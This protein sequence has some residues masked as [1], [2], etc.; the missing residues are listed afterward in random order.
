MHALVSTRSIADQTASRCEL[1]AKVKRG[2]PVA[3]REANDLIGVNDEQR[4]GRD[5]ERVGRYLRQAGKSRIY[6]AGGSG[7]EDFDLQSEAGSG[8]QRIVQ[9]GLVSAL[10]AE[11]KRNR[12]GI[13]QEIM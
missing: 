10:G 5:E 9:L 8:R 1:A 11:E 13:G 6:V 2:N 3:C 4:G 12:R 7:V